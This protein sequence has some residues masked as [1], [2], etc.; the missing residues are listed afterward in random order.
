MAP[1]RVILTYKDYE[2]LPSDGRIYEIHEGELYVTPA[3]TPYHQLTTRNLFRPLDA[4]VRARDLGEVLFAPIDVILSD[5][6]IVQP[7]LVFVEKA[8]LRQISSRGIE[9]PPTLAVQILSPSTAQVNR[10]THFQLFARHGL[11]YYWIVDPDARII[12]AH[13]LREG[14]YEVAARA[15]G[16]NPVSLPPFP[17]LHLIPDAIWP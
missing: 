7:D 6:T 5:I 12:E 4:H 10:T 2:A 3:P 16:P 13:V 15:T 17:D 11:P 8:R 1:Q 9:G 14:S